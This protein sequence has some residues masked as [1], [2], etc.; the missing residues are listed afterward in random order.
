MKQKLND[1]KDSTIFFMAAL[2]EDPR[3]NNQRKLAEFAKR[4]LM[5]LVCYNLQK[6]ADNGTL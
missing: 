1:M 4:G 3:Q 2:T 5:E 6:A